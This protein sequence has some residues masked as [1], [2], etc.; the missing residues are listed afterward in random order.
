MGRQN[1]LAGGAS[2]LFGKTRQTLLRLLYGRAEQ[3]HLQESLIQLAGLGRGAVQRE[4][5]FLARAGV[6]RRTVRGRQVY[7]QANAENP[8]YS[9]LRSLVVKTTGVADVLRAALAPLADRVRMAFIYGSTAKGTDH[10][11]SDVDVM[12]IGDASFAEVSDALG[13]AQQTVGRE[14]NPSVYAPA[15]FRAKLK[16]RHHFLR[17]VLKSEKIFLIGD[18]DELG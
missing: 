2:S 6:V 1:V 18:K 13:K 14:V 8:V 12:V 15:D 3:E 4:L 5:E 11:T 7:Y 10:R 16:A 17:S 9:E